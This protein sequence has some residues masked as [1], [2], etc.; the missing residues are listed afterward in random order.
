MVV[1]SRNEY[2]KYCPCLNRWYDTPAKYGVH[3]R[4]S[5]THKEYEKKNKNENSIQELTKLKKKKTKLLENNEE[6]M[7]HL[8]EELGIQSRGRKLVKST[9]KKLKKEYGKL[10]EEYEK[11]KEDNG[12][13]KKENKELKETISRIHQMITRSM[14]KISDYDQLARPED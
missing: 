1:T 2:P 7:R 9:N 4:T 6:K 5:V 14:A 8:E 10:E 12:K 3:R 13:L 11:V